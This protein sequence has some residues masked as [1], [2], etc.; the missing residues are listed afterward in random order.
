[1]KKYVLLFF[2]IYALAS[3]GDDRQPD[4]PI[5]VPPALIGKA[6][7]GGYSRDSLHYYYRADTMDVAQPSTFKVLGGGYAKDGYSAYYQ[8]KEVQGAQGCSFRWV[9]GDTA[10]DATD[11][12]V[13]GM[14]QPFKPVRK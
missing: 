11:V 9:A 7:G 4:R 14:Q 6:M 8:G 10:E 3:C 13:K 2:C 5:K 12:Y 1:M